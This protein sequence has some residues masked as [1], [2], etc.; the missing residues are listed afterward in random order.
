MAEDDRKFTFQ[1]DDLESDD[2]RAFFDSRVLRVW[3]LEG[4][5]KTFTIE[6]YTRL[7]TS[8]KGE[9][10]RQGLIRFRGVALPFALNSTNKDTIIALYGT[11]K[12][13][14]L[15]KRITLY[16]TTT[17]AFGKMQDCIRVKN[18]VPPEP[19]QR[20]GSPAAPG[21]REPGVD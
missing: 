8:Q 7:T 13:G 1:E 10:K 6:K 15:G 20:P 16:P 5:P 19:R 4:K 17:K 14:W 12:K 3:H 21:E 11:S 18:E 9:V 2:V